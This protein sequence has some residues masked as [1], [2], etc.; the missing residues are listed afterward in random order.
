MKS[1]RPSPSRTF[2]FEEARALVPA[3]RKLTE[4][5]RERLAVL[6]A[7]PEDSASSEEAADV[8][9]EWARRVSAL[10]ADVKG[11][12]LVDFDNGSGYYCW[13]F[14]EDDLAYYHSYEEGFEGRM[15]VH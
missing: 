2:S 1:A 14:P 4:T 7:S 15:R 9:E 5:A 8:V 3:I 13:R 10:G 6:G 12:W 11:L